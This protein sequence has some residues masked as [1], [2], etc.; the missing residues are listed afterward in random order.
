M[1]LL[2]TAMVSAVVLG[3]GAEPV[4]AQES[5]APD[6][7]RQTLTISVPSTPYLGSASPG[8]TGNGP[9]GTVTVTDSRGASAGTWTATVTATAFVTGSGSSAETIPT[10]A[11][12]YWSG[13]A[14]EFSG[15]GK[16]VPGQR[17]SKNA[18]RLNAPRKAFR[19]VSGSGNNVVSWNPTVVITPPTTAPTGVYRGTITHSVA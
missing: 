3:A 9:M 19:K 8:S 14:T 4:S 1:R 10:S 13:P 6:A 11:I 7:P 17:T 5:D 2:G 16:V 18:V 15:S 12:R